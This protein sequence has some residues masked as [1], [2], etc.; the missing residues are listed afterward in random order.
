MLPLTLCP[1]I[2]EEVD[3]SILD[4][5]ERIVEKFP[6]QKAVKSPGVE[7]TYAG[8]KVLSDR[9]AWSIRSHLGSA[10]RPIVLLFAHEAGMIPA[11]L[12]VLK[13]GNPY[14]AIDPELPPG[15]A[16]IILN[17][18]RPALMITDTHHLPVAYSLVHGMCEVINIDRLDTCLPEYERYPTFHPDDLAAI[19]Y[20]S[21]TSG[22]PKGVERSHQYILHRI[23]VET[24][25]YR[26][27]PDDIFSLIHNI[28]FGASQ[29]DIFDAL[30]NGAALSLFD[31]KKDGVAGLIAWLKEEQISFFHVP[32]DLFRQ[33]IGMLK[34]D[35]YFPNMRQITPSGRLYRNDVE[36]I[37]PHIPDD[38][39]L[40][41]RLASTETGMITRLKID[42]HS[43]LSAN[44]L[45]VGYAV[46]DKEVSIVDEGG[47]PL[48]FNQVGEIV[49]KSRY[50]A[51]G[52]WGRPDLTAR[53]FLP[54]PEN[55]DRKIFH[56]G[57]IG[58]MRPDGCL[59]LVGRKDSQV[60]IR[61]YRVELGEIESALVSLEWIK[62]A[63]VIAQEL[64][65]GIK[66]LVAYI[67]PADR[68]RLTTSRIRKA[69]AEN[70]PD[71]MIPSIFMHL[72][73]MPLTNRNKLDRNALPNPGHKRPDIDTEYSAPQSLAETTLARIWSE[74]L[75]IDPIGVHDNFF[76]LGGE[77]LLAA[78]AV[79][80]VSSFFEVNIPLRTLFDHPTIS[81]FAA[82][83]DDITS[84]RTNSHEDYLTDALSKLGY[85]D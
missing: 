78:Q 31:I 70:L 10:L 84:S 53:A 25:D 57:D 59:E 16:R 24:N 64:D 37:W 22:Q 66:R 50:L 49:V 19:F 38:C 81:D 56:L 30:L 33:F 23:W 60:K 74:I 41:Q 14:A 21:G 9:I 79:S 61:G 35:D 6:L 82:A 7:L 40:I 26:I 65:S 46:E 11:I 34:E 75:D 4:R 52:Y 32:T 77:S 3:L 73:K 17:D 47:R 58:R 18:L 13:S 85:G 12:G 45:P 20:T 71:Y 67:I 48:D 54:D 80:K 62:E 42:K 55:S 63:A 29:V 44:V 27:H 43:D 69:L 1:F 8:L 68:S 83:I 39:L 15:R 28:S 51:S 5:F 36:M 72:D 2:K 76:D